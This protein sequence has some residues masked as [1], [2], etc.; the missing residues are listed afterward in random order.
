MVKGSGAA[1]YHNNSPDELNKIVVRFYHDIYKKGNARDFQMNEKAIN[2]G[3]KLER[4]VVNDEEMALSGKE[5]R[6]RR[7]GTNMIISLENPLE[8]KQSIV[9]EFEWSFQIPKEGNLRMGTYDSTSFFVAYWYPEIAV[10]DDVDG[11]DTY[12]YT[13]Q[14]E[15]YHDFSNYN[16]NITVPEN[17]TVWATGI[18]QN[19]EEI[20]RK[21]ILEKYS[22]ART[23]EEIIN[24]INA[25]DYEKGIVTLPGEHTFNFVAENVEDLTFAL[26]DHY[27]WDLTSLVVDKETGR[28][29]VVGAAYKKESEDFYEVAEIAKQS[30][31]FYSEE[32]PGVPYPFPELTVFNG[33]GGM[34]S[35]MMVNDGSSGSRKGTVGVTSHEI[36]H[37]YFPF[38]MGTNE[39][40]YAWMD[41]GWATMLPFE[42]QSGLAENNDP[43]KRNIK[44]YSRFAGREIEMPLMVL[45]VFLRGQSYRIASYSRSG[46]G[47]YMLRQTLGDDLFKKALHAYMKRWAGKHPLP[48]DYFFSFNDATG[49]DLSWFWKPWYYEFGYPDLA[50]NN[51]KIDGNIVTVTIIKKGNIPVPVTVSAFANDEDKPEAVISETAG[52]WADGKTSLT[53]KLKTDKPITKIVLGDDYIPDTDNSNNEYTIEQAN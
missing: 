11:W 49:E 34:E 19:P 13:G 10:Y 27:L 40:K 44:S 51:V 6:I 3:M 5:S 20:F 28:R 26:S 33:Q 32:M 23:S 43:L 45:S 12:N 16:V 29:T 22:K 9:L 30:I 24:V 52:V 2:E 46:V 47:Y 36:A 35:P 18:L 4:L 39:R 53:L 48:Y 15:F 50:I 17:F 41:E 8:S 1:V 25:E 42:L 21:D 31:K 14:T 38:Y 37:S 7:T